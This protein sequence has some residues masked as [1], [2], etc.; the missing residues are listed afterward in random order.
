[1]G[2]PMDTAAPGE[3][4]QEAACAGSSDF[5]LHVRRRTVTWTDLWAFYREGPQ[6]TA[7]ALALIGFF[8]AA[9]SHAY[10]DDGGVLDL[11]GPVYSQICDWA[12]FA[13]ACPLLVPEQRIRDGLAGLLGLGLISALYYEMVFAV[14]LEAL[15]DR[16]LCLCFPEERR[17]GRA[18]LTRLPVAV[19]R[20]PIRWPQTGRSVESGGGHCSLVLE[21]LVAEHYGG[22]NQAYSLALGEAGADRYEEG[23]E[24]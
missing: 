9:M 1:M 21:G 3:A 12:R 6:R 14:Y 22:W 16:Q 24:A 23:G 18:W 10:D 17:S 4:W 11:D 20:L 5:L 7:P 19:G 13:V 8:H 15:L 2:D